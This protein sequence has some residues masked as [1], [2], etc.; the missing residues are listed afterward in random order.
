MTPE[1][2]YAT[3]ATAAD[4]A[5]RPLRE[6]ERTGHDVDHPVTFREGEYLKAG[7]WTVAAGRSA[8][9]DAMSLLATVSRCTSSLSVAN[10][11]TDHSMRRWPTGAARRTWPSA[12]VARTVA[13]APCG[14]AWR[15]FV[16]HATT[17]SV[18]PSSIAT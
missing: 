14:T 18:V 17:V 12:H 13:R 4:A 2:F 8:T 7:F 11:R 5:G 1:Q 15:S 9:R 16:F 6:I 10:V 3:V